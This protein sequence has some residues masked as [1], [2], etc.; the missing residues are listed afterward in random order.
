MSV[1]QQTHHHQL[2]Y[3]RRHYCTSSYGHA[4]HV[5]VTPVLYGGGSDIPGSCT[6]ADILLA[7]PYDISVHTN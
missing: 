2:S 4:V 7:L 5:I 6:N 1:T 3:L